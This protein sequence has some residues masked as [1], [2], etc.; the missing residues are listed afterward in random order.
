MRLV[1]MPFKLF[2]IIEQVCFGR[3]LLKFICARRLGRST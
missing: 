1:L 3:V 2:D